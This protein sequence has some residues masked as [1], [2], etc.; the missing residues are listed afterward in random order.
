MRRR[1]PANGHRA[2]RSM[3]QNFL[4]DPN[5][6]E[7]IVRAADIK[8]GETIVEIGPGKGVLTESLL[9][10][11]ARVT[12]IELDRELIGPLKE[13][14]AAN[15]NF[16]ILE[17]DVLDIDLSMTVRHP[18]GKV[19]ANLPYN[20]STAILQ[21]LIDERA[22]FSTFVL[23]F[24]R[25]VVERITAAAGNTDR[26]FLTVLVEAVF[27][28]AAVASVPPTAF[29]PRPKVWSS[30]V[31]LTHTADP[32]DKFELLR[33]L[34]S[35]AFAQKRMWILNNL[36]LRY[37]DAAEMLGNADV[38]PKRRAETLDREEWRRLV[39]VAAQFHTL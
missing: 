4:V 12:A 33:K 11:G 30:V 34:A 9:Q 14:F 26:G 39:K 17:S 3:G 8:P 37:A 15:P 35:A 23:M 5:I 19:V 22:A 32:I 7:K 24:Q 13:R 2:K 10:A 16:S 25:E 29:R 6:V 1:P 31:K 21:K 18:P 27:D 20:I 36:K 38:D 28:V